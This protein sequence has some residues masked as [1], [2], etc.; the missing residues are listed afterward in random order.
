MQS[1]SFEQTLPSIS[2]G[3]KTEVVLAGREWREEEREVLGEDG[4]RQTNEYNYFTLFV[5]PSTA[6][7]SARRE[8]AGRTERSYHSVPITHTELHA[9]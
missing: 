9:P 4:N 5:C 6:V 1:T 7:K 3:S 2:R 8:M